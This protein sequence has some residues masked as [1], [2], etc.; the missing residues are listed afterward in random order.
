[1]VWPQPRAQQR[2]ESFGCFVVDLAEAVAVLVAGILAAPV[3]DGL[4]FIAPFFQA[5]VDVIL[6][7]MDEGT[8]GDG[9]LDDGP[10]GR[11]LNIGQ[12]P[13]HHFAAPLQQA[14]DRWLL[15][16]QRAA[17]GSTP[18]P[19]PSPAAPLLATAAG[20]PLCPAVT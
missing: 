10:N 7:G 1:M 12:H 17:P 8:F 13:E 19:A 3:T 9:S 14:E 2:P 6:V 18:Q 16:L 5:G 11:L 4:M 15:L 20:L